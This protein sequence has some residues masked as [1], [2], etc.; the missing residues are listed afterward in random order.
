M[1]PRV[2]QA[3]SEANKIG[4]QSTE[5]RPRGREVA[6]YDPLHLRWRK[7][8]R[9]CVP[10]EPT[11]ALSQGLLDSGVPSVALI[12]R[13]YYALPVHSRGCGRTNPD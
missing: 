7:D 8:E 1:T 11:R 10:S 6:A 13:P 9:G 12:S 2:L 4:T 3:P 5:K